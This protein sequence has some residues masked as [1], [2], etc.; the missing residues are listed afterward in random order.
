[1][2]LVAQAGGPAAGQRDAGGHRVPCGRRGQGGYCAGCGRAG[3]SQGAF[4]KAVKRAGCDLLGLE[5]KPLLLGCQR[6]PC[7]EDDS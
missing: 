3:F 7:T 4:R 5:H 6:H 2:G 1:M